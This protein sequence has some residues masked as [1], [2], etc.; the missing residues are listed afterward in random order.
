M[1]SLPS[2]V[3]IVEKKENWILLEIEPLYPGFGVTIGNSLRRVL[4]SSLPGAAITQVK[5]KGV[6]HEFSTIPGVLEDVISI[7]MNLKKLRFKIFS[8]EPQ[9][10]SLKVSGG[11]KVLGLDFKLPPQVELINK[12][13]H[14]A[15]LTL[16]NTS[17]E[18]EVKIE[19]GLGYFPAEKRE[20]E[21]LE[22]GVIILDAV[23]TPIRKVAFRTENVR[24]GKRTDFDKLLLEIETDGTLSPEQAFKDASE[25]LKNH[26]SCFSEKIEKGIKKEKEVEKDQ[27]KKIEID[28]LGIS[29]KTINV[30]KG[31]GIK[32]LGGLLRR[33]EETLRSL[34]GIGDKSIREIKKALK[35]LGFELKR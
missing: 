35:D 25:V 15:T 28:K 17:L 3:K 4:L 14:I 26:F 22:P 24:V 10:G 29:E 9:T 5:I 30:L 1:I 11:K 19:K 23:F 16:K 18:M 2:K 27:Q 20:R 8:E 31:N 21:K 13:F 7:L 32:S 6:S 34:K 33:K 12:D